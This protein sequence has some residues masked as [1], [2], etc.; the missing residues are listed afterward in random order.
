MELVSGTSFSNGSALPFRNGCRKNKPIFKGQRKDLVR[1]F[2]SQ[3]LDP[4]ATTLCIG[5][6]RSLVGT[7]EVSKPYSRFTRTQSISDSNDHDDFAA[8]PRMECATSQKRTSSVGT[9]RKDEP[10]QLH[11]DGLDRCVSLS[12]SW[13]WAVSLSGINALA[14]SRTDFDSFTHHWV[15]ALAEAF[16]A[17]STR[18]PVE[19]AYLDQSQ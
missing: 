15:D 18:I 14:T 16:Q 17:R 9:V 8:L 13:S 3:F 5:K 19:E 1:G 6:L 12:R 2:H 11:A 7:R 4:V 10:H